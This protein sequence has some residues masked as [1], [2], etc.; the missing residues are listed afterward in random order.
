MEI[1]GVPDDPGIVGLGLG[2]DAALDEAILD[3]GVEVGLDFKLA[4]GLELDAGV[5]TLVTVPDR[6][7]ETV[8]IV[9]SDTVSPAVAVQSV[10][11]KVVV[12]PPLN[13]NAV[14]A[15]FVLVHSAITALQ[16]AAVVSE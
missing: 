9:E 2:V 8:G 14:R 7:T 16:Q 10:G 1:L 4:L 5:G 11:P 12:P 3:V 13:S 15:L 6:V